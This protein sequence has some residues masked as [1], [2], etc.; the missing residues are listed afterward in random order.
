MHFEFGCFPFSGFLWLKTLISHYACYDCAPSAGPPSKRSATH[1][2]IC[3]SS[4]ENKC[5]PCGGLLIAFLT[6]KCPPIPAEVT[7][8][9]EGQA[10]GQNPPK[11]KGSFQSNLG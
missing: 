6:A 2:P 9:E 4:V 7:C 10:T 8:P 11:K 3:S 5:M 1:C